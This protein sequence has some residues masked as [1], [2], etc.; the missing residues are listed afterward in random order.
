[1][2]SWLLLSIL[3]PFSFILYPL[4][5]VGKKFIKRLKK[6]PALYSCNHQSNADP[7][8]LKTRVNWGAKLMAKDS[9]F[10]KGVKKWFFTTL[11]AYPIN[12]GGNDIE[13]VKNTLKLL[14]NNKNIVVFPEGTRVK[15]GDSVE[16]KNG[17]VFF[18]LKSDCMVVPMVFRKKPKLFAI[19]KLVVG[20]PF[21][22][23]DIPEFN[24][25]KPTKEVLNRASEVLTEKMKY[26]K[27]VD[28]KEY[29]KMIK[30]K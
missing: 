6:Q 23:S 8:I 4:K 19:N 26:L 28:L 7:V 25:V 27:E 30:E 29:K 20:E 13:S 10:N 3:T 22:F 2:M 24:G 17:F 21:R 11:G 5:V 12:R 16:F 18:A 14:K 9:L 1:M 15:S